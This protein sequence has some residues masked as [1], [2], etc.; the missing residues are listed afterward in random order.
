MNNYTKKAGDNPQI[1]ISAVLKYIK[2]DRDDYKSKLETLTDYTKELERRVKDLEGI[3]RIRDE[4]ILT[5][6][7]KLSE[8]EVSKAEMANLHQLKKENEFMHAELSRFRAD[9]RETSWFKQLYE[10]KR[11]LMESNRKLKRAMNQLLVTHKV[12]HAL[13]DES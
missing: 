8:N 11:R 3:I 13:L 10:D 12:D 2:K 4:E 6:E 5:L 1:P 9:Y 7:Q